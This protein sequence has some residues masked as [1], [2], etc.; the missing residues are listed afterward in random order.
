[1][2]QDPI[3]IIKSS[4]WTESGKNTKVFVHCRSAKVSSEYEKFIPEWSSSESDCE[5]IR[6]YKSEWRLQWWIVEIA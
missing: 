6:D 2:Q 5:E 4:L 1:M 3:D